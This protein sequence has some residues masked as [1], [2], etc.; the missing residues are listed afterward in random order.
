MRVDAE[1][2]TL[3]DFVK[4]AKCPPISVNTENHKKDELG[5]FVRFEDGSMDWLTS[6]AFHKDYKSVESY[7]DRL[8]VERE[9]LSERLSKLCS[10]IG[11][12]LF[13]DSVSNKEQRELM[14]KQFEYM[15]QY[16]S[17]LTKRI[18]S[19]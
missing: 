10:F 11:S 2:M 1:P 5:Y 12:P 15:G 7:K 19:L 16:L 9:D 13:E 3:E 18:D 8:I 17:V 6:E 14:L 4:I